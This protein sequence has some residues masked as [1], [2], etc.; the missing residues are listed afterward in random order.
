MELLREILAPDFLLRNSVYVSLLVG[1]VCPLFG[2]FLVMRRMV[3]LGVALPHIS[4][5][6]IAL[7]LSLHVWLG[8]YDGA[9]ERVMAI[10]G[11]IGFAF[12]AI[13]ILAFLERKGRLLVE[14]RIGTAYIMAT[15]LSLLLLA[16]CP[17]A[18]RGW[19]NLFKGEIIT[20]SDGDLALG[21][22][23]FSI[24]AA[25][26]LLFRKELLLV[27]F[28]RDL[29]IVLNKRVL[30]WD[31][32]LYSLM[33]LCIS[34]AVFIVGPLVTFGF[35]LIPPMAARMFA[36][37][38]RQMGIIASLIGGIGAFGGFCAAY[39][40]D[41]PIGPSNVAMLGAIYLLATIVRFSVNLVSGTLMK[42][43]EANSG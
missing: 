24:L 9:N 25:I 15:A 26:L 13:L 22:I 4:A 11:S 21:A 7:A 10:V 20:V 16:K 37:S 3:F 38:M 2:V 40:W 31:V 29:A 5:A 14:G 6:G 39:H 18:E 19:L 28:D 30:L 8:D 42:G 23:S 17:Q 43:E 32:V 34:I 12:I 36:R 33:G 35:M 27:S 1:F 41:L